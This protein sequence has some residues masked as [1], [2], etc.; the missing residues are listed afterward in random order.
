MDSK[1]QVNVNSYVTLEEATEYVSTYYMT[2]SAEYQAWNSDS[3][4]DSDKETALIASTQALNNLKYNGR[5]RVAGQKLAFPRV[6]VLMPGIYYTPFVVQSADTS[7]MGCGFG[8]DNGLEAAKSAQIEN[9]LAHILYGCVYTNTK[10]RALSGLTS[11]RVDDVSESYA[12]RTDLLYEAETG[13]YAPNK[14][15][16]L[17]KS[18]LDESVF[19]L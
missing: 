18:W 2:T 3:L 9:A 19:T 5:K 8:N 6:N 13:L 15:K 16:V 10:K 4:S 11:K 1:I 14:V 12:N 7:L 17:L